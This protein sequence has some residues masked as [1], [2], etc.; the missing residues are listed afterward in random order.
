VAVGADDFVHRDGA[1]L[2]GCA[3]SSSIIRIRRGGLVI[4][5]W[6]DLRYRLRLYSTATHLRLLRTG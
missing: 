1:F 4:V 3:G 2:V 6:H 5:Y